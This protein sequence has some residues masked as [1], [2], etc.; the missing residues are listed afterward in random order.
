M[1]AVL[2]PP[3]KDRFPVKKI[4]IPFH[5]SASRRIQRLD[6]AGVSL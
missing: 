5:K 2:A 4:L 6:H 1:D 3:S